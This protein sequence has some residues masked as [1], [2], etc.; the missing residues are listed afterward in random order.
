MAIAAGRDEETDTCPFAGGGLTAEQQLSV[1]L[2]LVKKFPG[3]RGTFLII[4]LV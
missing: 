1:I 4:M 3:E 2:S